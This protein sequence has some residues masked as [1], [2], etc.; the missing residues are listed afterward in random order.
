MACTGAFRSLSNLPLWIYLCSTEWY[1]FSL[2]PDSQ[3]QIG[4][5]D[6]DGDGP[7]IPGKSESGVVVGADPGTPTPDPSP[8]QIGGGTPTPDPRQIGDG[9]GDG[10]RGFRALKPPFP[11]HD[12]TGRNWEPGNRDPPFPDRFGRERESGSGPGC[13]HRPAAGFGAWL[14]VRRQATELH[15]RFSE[16][17]TFRASGLSATV[18]APGDCDPRVPSINWRRCAV[19]ST[20]RN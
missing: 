16:G 2:I 10:D 6:S 8:R 19:R 18:G 1:E 15:G 12:H 17:R 9:D 14:R 3:W 13:V 11:D 4:C 7:P 5:G 20:W